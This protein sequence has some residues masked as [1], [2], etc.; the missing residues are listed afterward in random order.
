MNSSLN[1]SSQPN[2]AM[3]VCYRSAS[4]LCAVR[5][6]VVVRLLATAMIFEDVQVDVDVDIAVSAAWVAAWWISLREATWWILVR[7]TVVAVVARRCVV[8]D[9]DVI[10][11]SIATVRSA[12]VNVASD[13]FAVAHF[14][15]ADEIFLT[16]E[17]KLIQVLIQSLHGARNVAAIEVPCD[18]PCFLLKGIW[19]LLVVSSVPENVASNAAQVHVN[20]KV[21]VFA[22]GWYSS[23]FMITEQQCLDIL[24]DAK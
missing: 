5:L 17:I 9:S 6:A 3:R 20:A 15:F 4:K 14:D 10:P 16:F 7:I 21:K 11:E 2:V 19:S 22:H 8:D 13:T 23:N 24:V 18:S 12:E 1:V